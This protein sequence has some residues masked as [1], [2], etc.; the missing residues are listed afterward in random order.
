MFYC[1][2]TENNSSI[3]VYTGI[4]KSKIYNKISG[5]NNIVLCISIPEKSMIIYCTENTVQSW[6]YSKKTTESI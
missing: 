1:Y 2:S 4:T 5:I 3:T 6:I